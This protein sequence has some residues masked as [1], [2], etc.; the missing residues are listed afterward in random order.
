MDISQK[1]YYY[2]IILL[3]DY[4]VNQLIDESKIIC[5]SCKNQTK[6]TNSGNQF[7]RCLDF[8]LN[9]C[10]LCK[11]YHDSNHSIIDFNKYNDICFIHKEKFNSYCKNCKINLCI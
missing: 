2:I 4:K 10:S 1:I 7:F 11:Y 9:I 6:A 8:K 5:D 3:S